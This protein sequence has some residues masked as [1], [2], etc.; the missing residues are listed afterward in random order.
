MGKEALAIR[1]AFLRAN[2]DQ[3]SHRLILYRNRR[4]RDRSIRARADETRRAAA[5]PEKE[6][7]A[8]LHL[9]QGMITIC[10][11]RVR[12]EW[13]EAKNRQNQR[14]H[15]GI[16]FQLAALVFE[17]QFCLVGLDRTD[18][19][20]DQRWHAIGSACVESESP[21]VLLVVH[22]YRECHH[23]EEIIRIISARKADKRDVRISRT[24]ND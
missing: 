23:G 17:D 9:T 4:T 18:E 14:R 16:S 19:T 24:E 1:Q 15:G 2:K 21:V 6:L 8:G 10:I 13:D 12:Y 20:G 3:F 7:S 11:Y 5:L 22:A